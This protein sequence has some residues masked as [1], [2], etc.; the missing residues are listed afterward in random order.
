[1]TS[2]RQRPRRPPRRGRNRRPIKPPTAEEVQRSIH[3]GVEFLLKRQ[4]KDGSWGSANITRP[5]DIYAPVPGAHQAFKAAVTSLCI[6]ALIETGGS[7]ADVG[8]ALD[9][10]EAWLFEHL[11]QVPPLHAGHFLQR[12]DARLLDSS[13]GADAR[14]KARRRRSP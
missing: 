14:P 10:G 7:G 8:R 1:M 12:L 11:P 9:R 13:P 6:S 2:R 5:G 4:N 3:R